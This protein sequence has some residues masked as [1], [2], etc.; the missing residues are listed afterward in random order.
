MEIHLWCYR[1]QSYAIITVEV[2]VMKAKRILFIAS[3]VA[4]FGICFTIMNKHYD[5]LARYRYVTK[6]NRQVI[7]DHLDT[8][9]INY[10]IAQ[11][12]RPEQFLPFIDTPGF[13]IRKTLWYTKA[14]EIQDS[15]NHVIV[16]FVNDFKGKFEYSDLETLLKGYSYDT[17]R[18]FY[19]EDNDYV[20]NASIVVNPANMYTRI[21]ANESLYTYEPKDLVEVSDIPSVSMVTNQTSIYL[22]K[23]AAAAVV[24]LC[25]AASGVNDTTCGDMILVAGY[26]SYQDQIPMYEKMMLK[27]GKDKFQLYWD[28]PGQNEYQLGYTLRFQMAGKDSSDIDETYFTPV[29]TKSEEDAEETP[30]EDEMVKKEKDMAAWL[31]E[32]AYQ[33]GFTVRYPKD[34]EKITGKQYQPFTLRYVGKD[35]AKELHDRNI[36]LDEYTFTVK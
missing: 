36:T 24:E 4:L 35:V 23:E 7:L 29:E 10:M 12:L 19:E 22:K 34:K 13:D 33:Y 31:E 2:Y 27:H 3:L 26:I 14:K 11:Q 9:D 21:Q 15:S 25:A 8:D 30:Q 5:E 1:N 20:K 28:Y 6:D 32:N 17:L 16:S 18:T